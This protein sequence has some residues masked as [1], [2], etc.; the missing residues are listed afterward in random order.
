MSI[1]IGVLWYDRDPKKPIKE[2]IDEAAERHAEKFGFPPNACYV[3]VQAEVDH[4]QLRVEPRANILP[5]YFLVGVD[6][7]PDLGDT[8]M[9]PVATIDLG[10]SKVKNTRLRA[11]KRKK[12]TNNA[13]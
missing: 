6:V 9:P 11:G 10:E 12:E 3:N 4:D 7:D 5:H 8:A 13:G 2:K 1:K